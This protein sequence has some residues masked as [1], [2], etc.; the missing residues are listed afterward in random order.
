MLPY[1]SENEQ[2][3]LGRLAGNILKKIHSIPVE[4]SDIPAKTKVDKKILQLSRYESSK[5]RVANDQIAVEYVKDNI[6]K[7]WKEKPVYQHGDFHLGNLIYIWK[8][9]I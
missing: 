6:Q 7:I 2:Y 3:A 8:M 9:V 5:V 4:E 1:L